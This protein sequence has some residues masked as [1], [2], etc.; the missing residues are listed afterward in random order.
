[1]RGHYATP[2]VGARQILLTDIEAIWRMRENSETAVAGYCAF[3]FARRRHELGIDEPCHEQELFEK[4]LL[5]LCHLVVHEQGLNDGLRPGLIASLITNYIATVF[6]T[7]LAMPVG[8]EDVTENHDLT[9]D[10][11]QFGILLLLDR[12]YASGKNDLLS[13]AH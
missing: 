1:M 8:S 2:G 11:A 9:I 7:W 6:L 3:L 5:G 10:E 12:D 13:K 4:R